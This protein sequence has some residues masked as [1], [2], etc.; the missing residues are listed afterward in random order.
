M[1]VVCCGGHTVFSF[2]G[3]TAQKRYTVWFALIPPNKTARL[4][5]SRQV[6]AVITV[7]NERRES[8]RF[9]LPSPFSISKRA[10]RRRRRG[11]R[12]LILNSWTRSR[13]LPIKGHRHSRLP[14]TLMCNIHLPVS[15]NGPIDYRLVGREIRRR[16]GRAVW[17]SESELTDIEV[18]F[19]SNISVLL[20]NSRVV[21][22]KI[23]RCIVF[24]KALNIWPCSKRRCVTGSCRHV[25]LL[26]TFWRSLLRPW[27]K[28]DHETRFFFDDE[29]IDVEALL[30]S[31]N[32]DG[33]A[34]PTS[35]LCWRR[36]TDL[37]RFVVDVTESTIQRL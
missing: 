3:A 5:I 8:L 7:W 32:M 29:P 10:T 26:F 28:E 1:F 12:A 6:K 21:A 33:L 35:Q 37:S 31:K 23:L 13:Y 25:R 14:P 16:G 20:L 15:R 30:L 2:I 9:V 17:G 24:C 18:D 22:R 11:S 34:T 19:I 36:V 27:K 4:P